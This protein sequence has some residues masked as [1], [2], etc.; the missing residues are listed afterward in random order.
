LAEH[1]NFF[2]V[3]LTNPTAAT[4]EHGRRFRANYIPMLVRYDT[5]ARETARENFLDAARMMAFLKAGE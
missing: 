5:N 1:Y 3:D 2:V 4:A